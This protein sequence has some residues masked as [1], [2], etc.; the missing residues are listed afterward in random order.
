M[1]QVNNRLWQLEK[2]FF[3][4]RANPIISN[5]SPKKSIL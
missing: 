4:C 3:Q 1:V 5:W 2:T